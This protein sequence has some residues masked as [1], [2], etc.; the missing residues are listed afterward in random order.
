M[1]DGNYTLT[2]WDEPQNYILDLLNVT[3]ANG[4]TVDM[5][6]LPLTGWFTKFDGYVFNDVNR[7]GDQGRRRGGRAQLHADPA[8]ARELADGPRRDPGHHRRHGYYVMENAYPITEWLVLEAYNDRYYTT[9]VTYQADNQPTPTTVLGAGVDVS[10]LPIIGLSG[11]LDWGVHF[12]DADRRQRDRP[13]ERRHRRLGQLRH[14]PQRARPA[15]RGGR[16]LAAGRLRPDRSTC[17]RPCRCPADGSQPCDANGRLRPRARWLVCPRQAPQHLRHRD[18]AAAD[19]LHRPRR[20]RQR[21]CRT[22][23]TSRSCRS[24]PART[25]SKARSMG[26]Q[27]GPYP[28]D[29]GTSDANFGA[30]VDGNYGFGDGCFDGTL[31]A[32]DPANPVC[33]GGTFDAAAR[34]T[35]T[36]ST[37]SI[38]NDAAATARL[39]GH[40]GRGHQH[41]QRRQLCPAGPAAGVRRRA[42]H[43][44]RGRTA[45][46]DNYPA[47]TI[48]DPSGLGAAT[49]TVAASTPTDNPTFAEASAA[50]PTRARPGR[51]ATRS[52]C[53][54]QNGKSIV[55]TFNVFT[56]VPLPGRFFGLIVDDLN[57]STDPKSLLYG[58]KAGIPFSPVGIYDFANRLVTTSSPTT[59]A[60]STSS[61]RRPTGSAARRRRAS[62]P[63]STASS[64][65]TRASRAG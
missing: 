7:N 51:C 56:D 24:D 10:V 28:T 38:P 26:V 3:V 58:E 16:G 34:R 49:I 17:T 63:T 1:P 19:R 12:Y 47:Q 59:T 8:E 36:W 46:T 23:P 57:F 48:V 64:A 44:R 52:S 32:T 15:L 11:T 62:A 27:F 21:R 37:S 61:C 20:R 40:P 65:T 9:G 55:P 5:G 35:T 39:Q 50:R 25:A 45:A 14:H 33:V 22:R 60:C 42:P 29:Q 6:V 54:L 43:G 18:L 31:D 41:R 2:Y 4:E 30:A 53:A 13:A